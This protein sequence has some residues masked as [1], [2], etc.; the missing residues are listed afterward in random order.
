MQAEAIAKIQAEL[1]SRSSGGEKDRDK[2]R[3]KGLPMLPRVTSW[4]GKT[5]RVRKI[6]D[7]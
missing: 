2:E 1:N 5:V 3:T 4:R 6:L 7:I